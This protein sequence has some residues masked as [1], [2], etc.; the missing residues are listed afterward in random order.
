[1]EPKYWTVVNEN[2]RNKW[3]AKRGYAI[4]PMASVT[5]TMVDAHPAMN[6]NSFSKYNCAVTKRKE[7]ERFLN[8]IFDV[9][10]MYNTKGDFSIFLNEEGIVNEDIFTWVTVGFVHV[11]SSE[12]IPITTAIESGFILKSFN[13]FATTEVYDMPQVY[14]GKD[15]YVQQPPE[16]IPCIE[17]K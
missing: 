1:M 10:R 9:N 4:V 8:S 14:N 11:P 15:G 6:A 2:R 12:D 13:F 17:N 3:G 7:S 5:Q 16:F